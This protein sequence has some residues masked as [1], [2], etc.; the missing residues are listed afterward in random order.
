[1]RRKCAITISGR[2]PRVKGPG[3]NTSSADGAA[4]LRHARQPRRLE[5]ALGIDAVD[6]RQARADLVLGDRQ[7]A[8]L[9]VEGAGARP[10]RRAR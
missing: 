6:D 2:W 5:T 7:D 10:R 3:G 9:L 8:A 4:V 1:M